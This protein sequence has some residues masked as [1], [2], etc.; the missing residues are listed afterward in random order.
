M[1][2]DTTVHKM[3]D[4]VSFTLRTVSCCPCVGQTT[5]ESENKRFLVRECSFPNAK[6]SDAGLRGKGGKR[7]ESQD[8]LSA[9]P[10]RDPFL[11]L[12]TFLAQEVHCMLVRG[13]KTSD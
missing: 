7:N 3:L 2:S 12:L 10:L 9:V 13:S 1:L 6:A 4:F 8:T 5:V 11:S